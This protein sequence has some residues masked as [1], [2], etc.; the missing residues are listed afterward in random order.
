MESKIVYY[1]D[2]SETSVST[3]YW[4]VEALYK[5]SSKVE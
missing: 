3:R 1:S 5:D 2:Y 4:V